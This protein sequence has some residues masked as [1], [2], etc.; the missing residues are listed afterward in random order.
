VTLFRYTA[1]GRDGDLTS[2]EIDATTPRAA[3]AR[4]A[5]RG[6]VP[7][8]IEASGASELRPIA[9]AVRLGDLLRLRRRVRLEDLALLARQMQTLTRSGVPMIRA[10]RSIAET[11]RDVALGSALSDVAESMQAGRD[12]S[13]SLALHPDVFSRMFVNT[14]QVGEVSGRLEQAFGDLAM[15]LERESE[16]IKRIRSALRYPTMVMAAVI[17]AVTL[18]N[19]L[20]VPAF[21]RM[22]RDMQADLP[23]P[24]RILI[25]CSDLTLAYWPYL[26]VGLVAGIVG[27]RKWLETDRGRYLWHRYRMRIPV[28]GSVL[29]RA[30]LARFARGFSM[31]SRAG[32]PVVETLSTLG[33]SLDNEYVRERVGIIRE[34]ISRGESLTRAA[35]ASGLFTPLVLQMVAIGE[36]SGAIDDLVDE[37]ADYYEREVDH[38]LKRMADA[39]EPILIVV[40]GGIVL[41]LALAVYLPMWEMAAAARG[42]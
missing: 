5:E 23:L 8:T 13:H 14:V 16:T 28:V 19:I 26:L 6:A 32:V 9:P 10:L 17:G 1:R 4:I 35:A 38:D 12:F 21:A 37:V 40:L 27:V 34:H 15:Y 33:Q 2:G 42:G 11:S 41:V 25:A 30:T 3:A 24:T 7:L 39:I 36:E 18:I 20:V 22:F 31:A 29:E